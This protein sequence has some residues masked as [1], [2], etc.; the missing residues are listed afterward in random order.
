MVC[1]GECV[2]AVLMEPS[3][4]AFSQFGAILAAFVMI[5]CICAAHFDIVN[6]D[7]FLHLFVLRGERVK[8]WW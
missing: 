6:A 1:F 3:F 2:I 5:L 7:Q 8:A 4:F